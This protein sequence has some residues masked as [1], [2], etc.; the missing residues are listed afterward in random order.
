MSNLAKLSQSGNSPTVL[1]E[2]DNAAV[3]KPRHPLPASVQMADG[4]NREGN[5]K[6]ADVIN[7]YYMEKVQQI[8]AG[9][10]LQNSTR[11]RALPSPGAEIRPEKIPLLSALQTQAEFLKS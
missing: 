1:W 8:R 6:A 2:I 10:G 4:T 11:E 9:R 3:C 5:L 7:S